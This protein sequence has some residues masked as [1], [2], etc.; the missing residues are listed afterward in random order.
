MRAFVSYLVLG[1]SLVAQTTPEGIEFFE[2]KIRP[3]FAAKCY[4]CHNSKMPTPL[5]GLRVDTRDA[6]LKGGDS[7]KVIVPGDPASSRLV[8]AVSYKHEL[9]MPPTGKL[10]DEQIA[11]LEA[12]VKMGAPDPRTGDAPPQVTKKGIDFTE[13]RKFWAFHPVQRPAIPAVKNKKW[14]QSPVDAFLLAKLEQQ[15][16]EPASPAE[17]RALIRRVTFDLIGLPPT[18]AETQAFVDDKTPDAFKKVVERLLASP[19]Y[20][21]RWARHWLDL[22]RYAE[23]NG[24]EYDNDKWE[25]WRY[26]DYVIRSFNEDIPYDQFVREH[27]AG[28]LLPTK[29]VRK[30]GGSL[31][32]PLGTTHLWFNEVLNSATDSEKSRA[33]D[34]D[35]QIDVAS[36]AFLGLTVACARCH[37]HKFDPIPTADYYSLAGV[38]HSTDIREATLDTPERTAKINELSRRIRELNRELPPGTPTKATITYR[39]EDKIFERFNEGSFG[40]WVSQGIAFGERPVNDAVD[41]RSAGSDVFS[42]TLT[43]PKFK[44]GKELFLHVRI[45]GTK[46]DPTL[47]ERGRLRFTIVADGYKG[48]HIVPDGGPMK[49]KTLRLTFERERICYFEIVDRS[50]DGHIVVDEIVFSSSQK[51]PET[52][53]T[54]GTGPEIPEGL[55]SKRRELEAQVPD[56]EFAMI[57]EDRNPH[58]VRLHIRG[59]HKNLGDPVPRHFLQVVAGENQPSIESGSGRLQIARWMASKD[60]PLTARVMVNRIW[61]HHFGNGIVRSTD[62]F[63][64]MGEP[65]SHPELLDY[66]AGE[67]MSSGWSVK[68]I[69]RMIVLSSAYQ[70]SSL[71][72]E[73]AAKVDPSNKL[74]QHMPVRRLEA[75]AI[76]D[77]VLATAGTLDETLYGPSVP[78]HISQYQDG[79]GK[80][81]TGPLDG[82]GRRSIYIQ[83]R[84][85]FMTPLFVAFD[86]PSP[87]S[88]I[89]TRTVSTVP[90]QALMMMNNEF[91]AQQA[92]KWADRVIG[93]TADANQRVQQMYNTAFARPAEPNEVT[94]ILSFVKAQGAR[95]EQAVWSDVAHVLFNSAEF[96]YVP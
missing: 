33:D 84:R 1:S 23:T 16:L 72:S 70:M 41:S 10:T 18:A 44:T 81:K 71:A 59:N 61:K 6:L 29:R 80:P 30:D 25:P 17:R 47:K 48:Q 3:V 42:G 13:A 90:S 43:S 92:S 83:V 95:P 14:V 24:H 57:A 65:P 67:F 96:L 2:K 79:R 73:S 4:S 88:A 19:H 78:P 12:W 76:R 38:F 94:S 56:S 28:D 54:P 7:G 21:E 27:I 85:N 53:D 55:L 49:W 69:H 63:G 93:E 39:D 75:E 8:Q 89:G 51:P 77:S 35:N 86:Y 26:R 9:K 60:N 52:I 32:S 64:K 50:R 34:V 37:D 91:I 5:G 22:V 87:I 11:D 40:K 82:A 66:L 31:E 45:G 62:N 58:D 74:L 15:G 46:A 36:K 68:A 20:G